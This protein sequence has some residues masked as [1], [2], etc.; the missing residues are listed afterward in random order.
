MGSPFTALKTLQRT[1]PAFERTS[2]CRSCHFHL[3]EIFH[4]ACSD[5]KHSLS[6]ISF[7]PLFLIKKTRGFF[8][9]SKSFLVGALA[10]FQSCCSGK[11]THLCL[12]WLPVSL[13]VSIYPIALPLIRLR[14]NYNSKTRKH[15][16]H[17]I[18]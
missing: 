1:C 6:L 5:E 10:V 18:R 4:G 11:G 17:R 13:L 9:R 8:I 15:S 3:P 2:R 16:C 14:L 7:L 12:P